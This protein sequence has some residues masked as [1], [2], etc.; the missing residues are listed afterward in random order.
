MNFN[1]VVTEVLRV[2]QRP[3]RILD[4]RRAVNSA[5]NFFCVEGNF[6]RDLTEDSFDVSPTDYIHSIELS[7]FARFRKFRYIKPGNSNCVLENIS[8]TEAFN[9]GRQRHNVYYVVGSEVKINLSG[10]TPNLLVGW[11][12]YP[13]VLSGTQTFWLLEVSPYMVIDKA[14]ALLLHNLGDT[15]SAAR[16]EQQATVAFISAQRDYKYGVDIGG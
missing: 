16:H 1:E 4:A 7:E 2:A 8:P 9:M 14:C 10:Q 5:I 12:Q 3:D 15:T 6:A 13:P 11:F